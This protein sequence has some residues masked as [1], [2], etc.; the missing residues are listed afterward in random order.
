MNNPG[1]LRMLALVILGSAC[2]HLLVFGLGYLVG[3]SHEPD[4]Q[5]LLPETEPPAHGMR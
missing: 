4:S 3:R 1:P 5:T 2:F